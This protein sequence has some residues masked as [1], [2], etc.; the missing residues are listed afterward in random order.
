MPVQN[1][2][3]EAKNTLSRELLFND[4]PM[5]TEDTLIVASAAE[6]PMGNVHA[7][8]VGHK[9]VDGS[10]K[11]CVDI[12]VVKKLDLSVLAAS[13]VLPTEVNGVPTNV[14]ESP[15][16]FF[17]ASAKT[18]N[19][20]SKF[21]KVSNAKV[22]KATTEEIVTAAGLACTDNR[23]R[24]QRP[25]MAGISAGHFRSTAGTIS[26]FCRSTRTGDNPNEIYVLSNNHVFAEVNRGMP[27]DALLQPGRLDDG[28]PPDT[29]AQLSRFIP[30]RLGG[31]DENRVDAAIGRLIG[32]PLPHP[33]ICSIGRIGG[34]GRATENMM[35]RKHGRTTGLTGG[36]VKDTH[37]D[38]RVGMDHNDPFSIARFVDQ[39]RIEVIA[40]F[41][42]I[43]LGGD[44]GSL[45][46][47][48]SQQQAVGLYFAGPLNGEYGIANHI[49]AVLS[50]LAIQLI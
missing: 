7:V 12:Y 44:S 46:F 4:T 5:L 19:T 39:I 16:A 37:Y 1:D 21:S 3:I 45:V 29:F 40:P 25:A 26:C 23:Q 9:I 20:A 8:G 15:P 41:P 43:G 10:E 2:V 28:G 42:A 17:S 47:H 31:G 11:K 50:E 36:I 14:I 18:A 38:A 6:S 30:L 13:A 33:E 27:G 34:I 24:R 48:G 49:D 32:G 22:S 35:V